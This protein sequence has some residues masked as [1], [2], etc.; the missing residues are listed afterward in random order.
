VQTTVAGSPSTRSGLTA[1]AA[2]VDR[3]GTT[4]CR[5]IRAMLATMTGELACRRQD[6]SDDT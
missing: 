3:L 4:I 1:A 5:C 6:E 2:V